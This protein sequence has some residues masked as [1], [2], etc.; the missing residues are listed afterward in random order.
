MEGEEDSSAPPA[1]ELNGAD[2]IVARY[3]ANIK[4]KRCEMDS[5]QLERIV[6]SQFNELGNVI[7]NSARSKRVVYECNDSNFKQ[8]KSI[9]Q[10][11]NNKRRDE[12][13]AMLTQQLQLG[14]EG[15]ER[16][17]TQDKCNVTTYQGITPDEWQKQET[18]KPGVSHQWGQ[19]SRE[20]QSEAQSVSILMNESD[21]RFESNK[22]I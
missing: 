20:R 12:A 3:K 8:V 1:L 22:F 4:T 15:T 6:D 10:D 5:Q 14:L 9:L 13:L 18:H 2:G 17:L 7:S 21:S 19:R 11:D 16:L